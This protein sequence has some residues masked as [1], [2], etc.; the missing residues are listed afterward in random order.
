MS[1]PDA[2]II[3]LCAAYER[4]QWS[5]WDQ[6]AFLLPAD[7][8]GSVQRAG[9][10]AL[11]LPLDPAAVIDPSRI[12]SLVDGLLL[13]GG[14]DIDPSFYG[15]EPGPGLEATVPERDRFEIALARAALERNQPVLGICRGMQVINVACGG[16]LH[17]DIGNRGH[18]DS[19][20]S[21]DDADH[22]VEL[23]DGSLAALAAGGTSCEIKSHHHQAVDSVGEGLAVTGRSPRDGTC[24]A[25]E[26]PVNDFAL[27]VQWHPE[28]TTGD[29][30]I[31]TFVA[32]AGEWHRRNG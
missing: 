21:F 22:L 15:H 4:A 12:L 18:R 14:A 27:G 9:G 30:V 24:E 29:S 8:V 3:G 32:A 17:Q 26:L 19:L 10:T 11:M 2:P 28:V 23:V 1:R 25:I 31:A 6:P 13:A 5:V 16:T 7:Y 20:G